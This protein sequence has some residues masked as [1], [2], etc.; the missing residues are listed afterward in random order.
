MIAEDSCIRS[1]D[2]HVYTG[3][4][5][6]RASDVSHHI[7]SAQATVKLKLDVRAQQLVSA[8]DVCGLH[9]KPDTYICVLLTDEQEHSCQA[10]RQVDSTPAPLE[11]ASA[12]RNLYE[13]ELC[14][15]NVVKNSDNPRWETLDLTINTDAIK[16]EELVLHESLEQSANGFSASFD[17]H[18]LRRG[19]KVAP[20]SRINLVQLQVQCWSDKENKLIGHVEIQVPCLRSQAASCSPL[21]SFGR[22]NHLPASEKPSRVELLYLIPCRCTLP[23]HLCID[24]KRRG[25]VFVSCSLGNCW[26]SR[27]GTP[28]CRSDCP[29]LALGHL[30]QIVILAS[31]PRQ[32]PSQT[33]YAQTPTKHTVLKMREAGTVRRKRSTRVGH[34]LERSR[35][36]CCWTPKGGMAMALLFGT[37]EMS[38]R[39]KVQHPRVERLC[40]V[41]TYTPA[42]TDTTADGF[43][44]STPAAQRSGA[45]GSK[46]SWLLDLRH[47]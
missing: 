21:F 15:S 25:N 9:G 46:Q 3:A 35:L 31:N 6:L 43:T 18:P 4:L 29:T 40:G 37:Q 19:H 1:Q 22:A 17:K 12:R 13:L 11:R 14:R 47:V 26:T 10:Q 32:I 33:H 28:T 42:R 20:E 45:R 5:V 2:A 34:L 8:S 44:I 7:H 16:R 23:L 41:C 38:S 30:E 24:T 36:P 39:S 27:I